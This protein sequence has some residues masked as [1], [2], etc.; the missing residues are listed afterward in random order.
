MLTGG[1]FLR[2]QV[3]A[4]LVVIL[5]PM[6]ARGGLGAAQ[7]HLE[8]AHEFVVVAARVERMTEGQRQR[9]R[10]VERALGRLDQRECAGDFAGLRCLNVRQ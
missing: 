10:A 4:L 3:A 2:V 8:D 1:K 7:G 5:T 9:G 6:Q